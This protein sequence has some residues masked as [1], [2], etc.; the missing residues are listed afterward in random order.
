MKPAI[1]DFLKKLEKQKLSE[2]YKEELG[3]RGLKKPKPGEEED[4]DFEYESKEGDILNE[5]LE[6]MGK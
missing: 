2:H 3:R 4:D 6:R 5:L 1:L